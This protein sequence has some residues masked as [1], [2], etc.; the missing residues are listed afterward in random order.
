MK[1][2]LIRLVVAT[3]LGLAV[4]AQPVTAQVVL[5]GAGATF[6]SPLYKKWIEIYQKQTHTRLRYQAI[7]SGGGIKALLQRRVD[8]GATDAILSEQDLKQAAGKIL[9]I[10]TCMS[11]VAVIYHLSEN[12]SLHLSADT[13]ADIFMGK[14]THWSDP[15]LKKDNQEMK[16]PALPITV[17][18][19]SESSGT[20]FIFTDYLSKASPK[21]QRG[22]GRGKI[23]TWPTGIG[24]EKNGG[25]AAYVKK[26]PGSIGYVSLNYAKQ[27]KLPAALVQNRSGNFI[28]PDLESVSISAS[29]E[30]PD[31]M[32]VMI[33]DTTSPHGYPI[34]A[35]TYLIVYQQQAYRYRSRERAEALAQ[36][37]CWI[38]S[39]GQAHNASLFYARLPET[40]VQKAQ[41]AICSMAFRDIQ[42]CAK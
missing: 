12:R 32:R 20:T 2:N 9:H 41:K 17:V 21:W 16:L 35:F 3:F 8:F 4:V 1:S 39:Q 18:H 42:L 29:V 5:H 22:L 31:D 13:L 34:S 28:A 11:G 33:T 23:V 36:F 6:P 7:G 25:V 14:I 40:V 10:P 27:N 37:L 19:R 30:I 15:R 26:I 24:V 38:I